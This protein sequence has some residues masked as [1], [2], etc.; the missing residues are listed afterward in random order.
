MSE[1]LKLIQ[2]FFVIHANHYH[3]A[4][5]ELYGITHFYMYTVGEEKEIP[6]VPDGC[7]DLIFE[8]G[9]RGMRAWACGTV[10]ACHKAIFQYGNCY[11][12][13]RFAPGVQPCVLNLL[14]GELVCREVNLS[15][16]SNCRELMMKMEEQ[17]NFECCVQVFLEEYVKLFEKQNLD[18]GSCA[19][20]ILDY[21]IRMIC[22]SKGNI[23]I[24]HIEEITGYSARYIGKIFHDYLGYSPKQLCKIVQF[25]NLLCRMNS[26]EEK[27]QKNLESLTDLAVDLGYY[28]Q[29][30][31]IRDFKKYTNV[32]PKMYEKII[33]REHYSSHLIIQKCDVQ[34]F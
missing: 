5:C 30:Q 33:S 11:F 28:D 17:K 15:G 14:P 3:K 4:L 31:L 13:V 10:L 7:V 34:E 16:Q 6:A 18:N 23:R 24:G 21:S 26:M 27:G 29:P 1:T 12:G 8:Y 32:T 2:P 22:E 25:Q 9:S 20:N 19:K